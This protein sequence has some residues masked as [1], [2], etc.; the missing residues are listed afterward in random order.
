MAVTVLLVYFALVVLTLKFILHKSVWF[1]LNIP[2]RE[3]YP[4]IIELLYPIVMAAVSSP[5]RRFEEI[6][7]YCE[8]FPDLVKVWFGPKIG[9]VVNDPDRMKKVLMSPKCIEKLNFVYELME[10]NYGLISASSKKKWKSHRKFFNFSFSLSIL[11]GFLPI[12][13]ECSDTLVENLL[14]NSAGENINFFE[15]AKRASFDILCATSLGTNIKE[16]RKQPIYEKV[17]EAFET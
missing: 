5:E 15:Y 3:K 9:I 16:Y 11:E 4:F 6:N 14:E 10:R 2:K 12:Y 17:F 13:K 1:K 8:S 7:N